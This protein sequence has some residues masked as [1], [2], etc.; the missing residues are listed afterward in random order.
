MPYL[1]IKVLTNTLT[2]DIVSFEQLG[3]IM[4]FNTVRDLALAFA[5]TCLNVDQQNLIAGI[6]FVYSNP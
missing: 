3:L 5:N 2:N 6:S 4:N 1:M